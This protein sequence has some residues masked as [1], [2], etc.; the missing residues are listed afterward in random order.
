MCKATVNIVMMLILSATTAERFFRIDRA[1]EPAHYVTDIASQDLY[2]VDPDL[3]TSFLAALT[4]IYAS[5]G[6]ELP[7]PSHLAAT[8]ATNGTTDND[9]LH[10]SSGYVMAGRHVTTHNANS[11]AIKLNLN[12]SRVQFCFRFAEVFTML[13]SA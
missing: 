6:D 12:S 8:A 4:I 11:C 1:L 9:Q 7:P 3:Q 5:D 13:T 10:Y 2:I